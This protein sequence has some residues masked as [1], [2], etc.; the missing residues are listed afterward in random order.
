MLSRRVEERNRTTGE[1]DLTVRNAMP[2]EG[3]AVKTFVLTFIL[4]AIAVAAEPSLA[5]RSVDPFIGAGEM[6]RSGRGLCYKFQAVDTPLVTV[7]TPSYNQGPFIRAT[8]E[9]VLSQQYPHVEYI[10]MD[11]GST[12]ETASVVKDYASRLT[13]ISEKDRGQAHAINKGFQ[14]AR[15]SVLAWLNSDDLYLPG[16]IHNA[17][18]AFRRNPAA[19]AVYGEGYLIDRVG[20]VKHRFPHTEPLNLWKLVY[21][22]DYILQQT[23]YFRREALEELGYLD[24][25]LHYAMDWD[26]L[27]RLGLKY[28]LVYVPEYM[29]CL[30]EYPE[31]KSFAGGGARIRE[32]HGMLRRYTGLRIPPG[33]IVYG[34]ETY[35]KIWCARTEQALGP[36]LEFVSKGLQALIRLAAGLMIGHTLQAQGVYADGW[37]ARLF[38]YMLPP[39]SGPLLV[40]GIVPAQRVFRGQKLRIEANGRPLGEFSL[41]FGD[42]LVA[43][44]I[45]PELQNQALHLKITSSRWLVPSSLPLAGDR[46]RL[47]FK[48]RGIR[49]AADQCRAEMTASC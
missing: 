6:M 13:F 37:A 34:L 29:G 9:S 35:H 24:E 38:R 10:I 14:M 2:S 30:R 27:I 46:R 1:P 22:S 12:D 23:V 43:V 39:G 7:V 49:W 47:A 40:E 45:P 3:I 48:L 42:F 41:P 18:E 19:G 28:P 31:A 8:I 11:G 4:A 44:E 21:L 25:G 20:N 26:I 32:I 15:G 5:Y 33:S 36:R 17:V 16:A